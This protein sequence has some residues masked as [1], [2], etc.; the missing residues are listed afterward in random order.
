MKKTY[1]FAKPA[2][3]D[4]I[5]A[6]AYLAIGVRQLD[7]LR[8]EGFVK[9]VKLRGKIA[10]RTEDLDEAARNLPYEDSGFKDA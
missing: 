7:Y 6:A 3:L 8:R 1:P 4:K 10:F 2:L 9:A 5:N